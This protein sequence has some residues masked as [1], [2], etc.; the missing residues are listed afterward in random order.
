MIYVIFLL[1]MVLSCAPKSGKERYSDRKVCP[2]NSLGIPSVKK[3]ELFVSG[4]TGDSYVG[5]ASKV[6]TNME[7]IDSVIKELKLKAIADL[8]ETIFLK[9]ETESYFEVTH[10]LVNER[11]TFYK[12]FSQKF[13]TEG[14]AFLEGV[15]VS[16]AYEPDSCTLIAKASLEASR[17]EEFIKR[18]KNAINIV[19]KLEILSKRVQC[20]SGYIK[21]YKNLL[22]ELEK[23]T[24]FV[25]KEVIEKFKFFLEKTKHIC[26]RYMVERI[27]L[28]AYIDDVKKKLG[29][30]SAFL[31]GSFYGLPVALKYGD[32]WLVFENLRLSCKVKR[33][34]TTQVGISKVPLPCYSQNPNLH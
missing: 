2:L 34:K 25:D 21:K 26:K 9:V 11:E 14:L 4:K 13:R 29:K 17:V 32:I 31:D 7:Y 23:H 19:S 8:T 20:D 10:R 33:L 6:I 16:Y 27:P 3:Y 5:V 15:L 24:L 1:L 30:P 28:G 18:L 22:T 12:T